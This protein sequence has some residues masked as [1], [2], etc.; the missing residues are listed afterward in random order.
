[1]HTVVRYSGGAQ[2]AHNVVDGK[3]HHTFAQFGSGT[4][5]GANTHLSRF[6]L[7]N[8]S[9]LWNEARALQDILPGNPY[10]KLSV[11][12]DAL[13]T[14]PVHILANQVRERLRGNGRHGSC[15]LGIGETMGYALQYPEDAIRVRDLEN[16]APYY[17]KLRLLV[18]RKQEELGAPFGKAYAGNMQQMDT[19]LERCKYFTDVAR[20]VDNDY[21]QEI[22][23]DG[24]TLFEGAQGVLLD[25]DFGFHPYT[26][27]SDTT[28]GNAT[29]LIEGFSGE[30]VRMGVTRS[31]MTRHGPG[32]FPSYDPE[33]NQ[34]PEYHNAFGEWQREFRRG[35]LDLVLLQYALEVIGGVDEIA[36]THM[37][38]I[39]NPQLQRLCTG[40]EDVVHSPDGPFSLHP[41][42]GLDQI[43][44][45]KFAL[46]ADQL[47]WQSRIAEGLMNVTRPRIYGR[48]QH[49]RTRSPD[50]LT[51]FY[52]DI[53]TTLL[54]YGPQSTHK[55]RV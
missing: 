2:C 40:Y 52:F 53:P 30:V 15:G 50:T 25:Q 10:H 27:W 21:L 46:E 9:S 54:S 23:Q 16:L 5:A 37:D 1:V 47:A 29:K 51:D 36:M 7:V 39:F 13:V 24:V 32:P 48:Q 43:N 45:R 14:T 26:T 8:P 41:R 18:D 42:T 20:I 3:K 31:Y 38:F 6:M 34:V 4:L 17:Q 12:R 55:Q 35:P 44:V 49:S 11:E 19:Y 33:M 28:F 22:M